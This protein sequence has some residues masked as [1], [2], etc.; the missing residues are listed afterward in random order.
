MILTTDQTERLRIA[1]QP[2]MDFLNSSEFHPHIQV[3]VTS[4][5][6]EMME[7]LAMVISTSPVLD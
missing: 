7:G 6:A 3:V 1:A 2:L 4:T 5:D